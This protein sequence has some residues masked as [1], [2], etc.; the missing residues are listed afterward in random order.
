[1]KRNSVQKNPKPN[2]AV[3][4]LD[5]LRRPRVSRVIALCACIAILASLTGSAW[6]LDDYFSIN[7][8]V[9]ELPTVSSSLERNMQKRSY[10]I[11]VSYTVSLEYSSVENDLAVTVVDEFGEIVTGY[12]FEVTITPAESGE[13]VTQTDE[14]KDGKLYF[15]NLDDGDY[16]VALA[17]AAGY[18]TPD[19]PITATV[20]PKLSYEKVDVSEKIVSQKE[21]NL[22]EDDKQYGGREGADGEGGATTAPVESDTVEF[23]ASSTASKTETKNT[24]VLVNGVQ[25]YYYIP[26]LANGHLVLADGTETD[27]TATLDANGYL[28]GGTRTTT[29]AGSETVAV[30]DEAGT[31]LAHS[32]GQAYLTETVTADDGT[33]SIRLL[34]SSNGKLQ[35]ADGTETDITPV[36]AEDGTVSYTRPTSQSATENVT[37]LDANG[38][39]L[40]HSSGQAYSISSTVAKV[41]S[42][43]ITVTT[44][45]GWQTIDGKTY[46]YN[47][48]GV[49]VTGRQVIQ[50]VVYNFDSNGA[51]VSTTSGKSLGVDVSTWQDYIDWNK[52][53]ASGIDFAFI[54]LG[55][56]GYSSGKLVEDSMFRTNI[57]NATAAGLKVGVY[58]FTQAVNEQEAVEEASMCLQLVSGYS[59]AYPIAI[60]I[61]W[62]ASNARTNYMSTADRTRVCYAFCQTIRNAGYTPAV[63]A[64]KY[65]FTSMLN[66]SQLENNVIWLAHYTGGTPS[67]YARRYDIWQ[68]SSVGTVNGISG[69]VDMNISYLGY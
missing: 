48:N 2:A 58:F 13:P 19:A 17:P 51:R 57:R 37:V 9:R 47:K 15:E 62:A 31:L 18:V 43:N 54:R 12:P 38:V 55:F 5:F 60:D 6:F 25:A 4:L 32:S 14:D 34:L 7:E 21:V 46:Y 67:S 56:R 69:S 65:Y 64:N 45:Y 33:T 41:T 3:K 63:Y 8:K 16:S 11:S 50:G 26:V 66:T 22:A 44:Y 35:L 68:Y 40:A 42:K 1:M 36:T 24:P 20:Q 30:Y 39:I 59:L 29:T 61:E 52:V 53:K 10:S 28:T 49:K 23:V 27:I